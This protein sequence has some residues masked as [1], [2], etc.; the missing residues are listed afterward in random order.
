MNIIDTNNLMADTNLIISKKQVEK[1]GKVLKGRKDI[2]M[3]FDEAFSIMSEWRSRH[4]V[5]LSHI[6]K[7]I[8]D[9]SIKID[10]S[11]YFG[12]RLKREES[13][14]AKLR[15]ISTLRLD[16]MQDIAG[17]RVIASNID[18]LNKIRSEL[19]KI[20]N[21]TERDDYIYDPNKY[22]YDGYKSIHF[23]YK[24]RDP[25]LVFNNKTVEIQLR[26]SIQHYWATTVEI[27]DIFED[28]DLK[29]G[30]GSPEW[31]R[32]FYLVSELFGIKEG[33]N[34]RIKSIENVPSKAMKEFIQLYN[35]MDVF[36]KL[37]TYRAFSYFSD[38]ILNDNVYVV[39]ILDRSNFEVKNY[40][41]SNAK[42]ARE[43]H[44][45]IEKENINNKNINV[46]MVKV[47]SVSELRRSYKNYFADSESFTNL[48]ELIILNFN[49]LNK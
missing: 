10:P 34:R 17:C 28:Q 37:T 14:T 45:K 42:D 43:F 48:V 9:I 47:S 22:R 16:K 35:S 36:N 8:K 12:A 30:G 7:T 18:S 13:I 11:S 1:A 39:L 25:N 21:I 29:S 27:I 33:V 41:L 6:Y 32:F 20:E 46:V 5:S 40:A 49:R 3:S 31:R 4:D 26:T 15:K 2:D 44:D 24:H 19:L 23:I 38:D